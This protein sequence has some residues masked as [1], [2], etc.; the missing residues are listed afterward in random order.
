VTRPG[1]MAQYVSVPEKSV[2][3]IGDLPFEQAAF[4]E[5]LSCVL[6]GLERLDP[7]SAARVAILGAGPI[8]MLLMQAVRLRAAA[9]VTL[10]ERNPDRAAFA[11]TMGADHV[12]TDLD[13][14]ERDAFDAVI[15]AT[16]SVAVMARTPISPATAGR[17]C[18]SA[19]PPLARR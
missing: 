7:P 4:M 16:G 18:S 5:P 17:S 15:D 14:L 2:F 10:V 9:E 1:G 6:H 13:G 12:L 3:A 8:G 19:C 11:K